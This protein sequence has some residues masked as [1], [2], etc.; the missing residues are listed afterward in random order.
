MGLCRAL[1]TAQLPSWSLGFSPCSRSCCT[2]TCC[3]AHPVLTLVFGAS[4]ASPSW[5]F[6]GRPWALTSP[7]PPPP[8]YFCRRLFGRPQRPDAWAGKTL[9]EV[10]KVQR[11][12]S[13]LC[14]FNSAAKGPGR[15]RQ[16]ADYA[17]PIISLQICEGTDVSGFFYK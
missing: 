6:K 7:P 1:C 13:K 15:C 12:T 3:Y 5:G 9:T 14:S 11:P 4:V 2:L 10:S 8:R 17:A 16:R